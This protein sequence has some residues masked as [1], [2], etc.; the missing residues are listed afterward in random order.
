MLKLPDTNT[1]LVCSCCNI[2]EASVEANCFRGG[3]TLKASRLGGAVLRPAVLGD[4]SV[5]GAVHTN[6]SSNP[7]INSNN[8]STP[9]AGGGD[10]EKTEGE[11]IARNPFLR[12]EQEDDD[13]SSAQVVESTEKSDKDD[14]E[15]DERP[16]PLS[17]LRNNGIERP[18]IFASSKPTLPRVQ[19]SGFVFGQNVHERVIGVRYDNDSNDYHV[20]NMS[21]HRK[22]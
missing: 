18:N 7:T 12:G 6:S 5:L 3:F 19:P 13:D 14:D 9:S 16:D 11:V 1:Y 17:M 15:I 10:S 4:S 22:R 20:T 21:S 2:V 8:S